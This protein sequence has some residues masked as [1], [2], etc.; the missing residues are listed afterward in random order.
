MTN[1]KTALGAALL[2]LSTTGAAFA[3]TPTTTPASPALPVT[4]A[5]TP[6]PVAGTPVQTTATYGDWVLRCAHTGEGGTGPQTCE[7]VQTLVLQ[8]QQQPIA[9]VA[10][11]SID[12]TSGLRLT[13]VVPTAISFSKAAYIVGAAG[14]ANLFDLAWRRCLPSGCFADIV[15]TADAL[16]MIRARSDPANL[17]FRDAGER[18]ITLPFSMRGLSQS[19]D[20]LGKET[21]AV[22]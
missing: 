18:D 12:K 8:G 13:V 20:A 3:E 17:V 11:G 14:T 22:R 9:Q 15:L 5:A 21:V 7:V 6:A 19:L 4:N 1:W 2:A 10:I 16:K